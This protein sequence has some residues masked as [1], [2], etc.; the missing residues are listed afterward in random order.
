MK[1]LILLSLMMLLCG[2]SFSQTDTKNKVVIDTTTARKIAIDL[3]KGDECKEELKI[4][5]QNVKL[6]NDKLIIKDSII[7]NNKNQIINLD[8]IVKGK[9]KLLEISDENLSNT[10]KQLYKSKINNV[11]WKATTILSIGLSGYLLF[12]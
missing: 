12:K 9:D 7:E 5:N 2:R 8:K 6:L 10:K 11:F 3:V 1:K 4:V